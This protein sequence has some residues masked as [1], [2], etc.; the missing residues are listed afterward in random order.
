MTRAAVCRYVLGEG[1]QKKTANLAKEVEEQKAKMKE[2]AE[3]KA[4]EPKEELPEP[5]DEKVAAF[6]VRSPPSWAGLRSHTWASVINS[7]A[8]E[9][10]TLFLY[11]LISLLDLNGRG[12]GSER[13]KRSCYSD[14]YFGACG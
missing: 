9:G 8:A 11:Y 2:E 1:V 12:R 7:F 10:R 14:A 5:S 13:P 3:A 4:A 6:K